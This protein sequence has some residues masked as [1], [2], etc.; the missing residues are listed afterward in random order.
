MTMKTGTAAP[1]RKVG[2]LLGIGIFLLPVIFAWF[3][4]RKGH[5]TLSRV[6]SFI[7][8]VITLIAYSSGAGTAPTNNATGANAVAESSKSGDEKE[9]EP[10]APRTKWDYNESRDEMRDD[11]SKFA[12]LRS[13]NELDFEFPYNGGS[14]AVIGLRRN[15][16]DGLDAYIKVDKGQFLCNGFSGTS[17]SV[18]F[19]DGPVQQF[20]CTDSSSG[21]TEYAF[22]TNSQRFLTALKG[23]ERVMIEAEFFQYGRGQYTFESAGLVFE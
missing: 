7:W 12:T 1:T 14:G 2:I 3:T 20:S 10:A 13:E 17:I 23:S 16:T 15:K 4:L 9:A 8:L 6:L 21:E 5:S 22:I 19:D 18:K 11:V